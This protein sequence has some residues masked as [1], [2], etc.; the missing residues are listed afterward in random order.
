MQKLSTYMAVALARK[1]P[2]E[3]AERAKLHLVDT[4]AA[5]ISG[6]RLL[7]GKRAIA[8][9]KPFGASPATRLISRLSHKVSSSCS[10]CGSCSRS[11]P[12]A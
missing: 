8:Y 7:P 5:I 6:S 1:L 4:F 10:S 2:Q 12:A 11:A 3:V 9:V